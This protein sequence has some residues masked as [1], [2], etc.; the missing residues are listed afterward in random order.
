V[1]WPGETTITGEGPPQILA[2]DVAANRATVAPKRVVFA[3]TGAGGAP[4]ATVRFEVRD[5]RPECVEISVRARPQ[6]R[7]IRSSDMALFNIDNLTANVLG[8]VGVVMEIDPATGVGVG[9]RGG[10]HGDRNRWAVAGAV[11]ERRTHRGR[12]SNPEE[13]ERV[14][15]TYREHLVTAPVQAVATLHGYSD[16]TA[17]R[18]VQEARAAGLLPPTSKGKKKA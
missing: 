3:V 2:A 10:D 13:L 11:T 17:A 16:R 4:D 18:R 14:A 1:S 6:G 8:E 5:G 12:G 9:Y 7:G 15:A